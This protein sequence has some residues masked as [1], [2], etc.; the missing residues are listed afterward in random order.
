MERHTEDKVKKLGN[1]EKM[2]IDKPRTEAWKEASLIAL[3]REN[4]HQHV[5]L[6]LVASRATGCQ[7]PVI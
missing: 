7:I 5:D 2:A 6:G 3:R 1:R 4:P